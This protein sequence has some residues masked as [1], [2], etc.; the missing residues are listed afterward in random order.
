MGEYDAMGRV[1]LLFVL[2]A[3]ALQV[4]CDAT[5]QSLGITGPGPAQQRRAAPDDST[6]MPPGLPDPGSGSGT[7][8]R[9]Y[10]YN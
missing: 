8:Q 6:V 7:D 10:R 9:F 2:T 5:P 4:G 1:L 3:A